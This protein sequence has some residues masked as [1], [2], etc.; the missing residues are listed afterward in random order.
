MQSS[1]TI[2]SED[3][4]K[5]AII[6]TNDSEKESRLGALRV[7]IDFGA[8]RRFF[9]AAQVTTKLKSANVALR[10]FFRLFLPLWCACLI[11]SDSCVVVAKEMESNQTLL[12]YS[13]KRNKC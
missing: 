7:N 1:M 11:T 9:Y 6:V 2:A 10:L 8:C 5:K 4:T 12:Q 3:E 13:E